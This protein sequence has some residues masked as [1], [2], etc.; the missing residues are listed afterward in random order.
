MFVVLSVLIP[1][2]AILICD[3]QFDTCTQPLG[4]IRQ[5]LFSCLT[6]NP[7]SV[8]ASDA[9]EPA[10]VCYSCSISCHGEHE[11]VELFS[12]RNFTCDCGTTRIKSGAACTLRFNPATDRKGDVSGEV[13]ATGNSYNQ[14]FQ[15]RFC[16]CGQLYNPHSEKGT[17]FQ[18]L[19]L[20][21]VEEGGCGEDWWHAECILGLPRDWYEK[22][23]KRATEDVVDFSAPKNNEDVNTVAGSNSAGT[24][25]EADLETTS[26]GVLEQ[27]IANEEEERP[28]PPGFP[29]EDD[30]EHLI[31]YKCT[32]TF[33]WITRYAGSPGFLEAVPHKTN[34]SEASQASPKVENQTTEAPQT[35]IQQNETQRTDLSRKRKTSDAAEDDAGLPLSKRSQ[36]SSVQA[37]AK[38]SIACSFD[39]IATKTFSSPVSLFLSADFRDQLCRCS[40]C[41]PLLAIHPQLLEEED[42]YEPPLS[43]G[44]DSEDG[45]GA[46]GTRSAGSRSLLDRGEAALSNM[47]RVRAIEGVM[48]YNHIRDKVKDFLKPFAESGTAVGAEDIKKYFEKLRGDDEAIREAAQGGAGRG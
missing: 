2:K 45:E 46:P 38:V 31:C 21:T 13:P 5:S 22:N 4:S 15:N 39:R 8:Q 14:N 16:G 3:Q 34:S 43:A 18:C 37:D 17:M 12:R 44:S 29:A 26:N 36:L 25:H 32:S 40:S 7:P 20:G 41:F 24:Q 1:R 27:S 47:D 33:P 10:G 11:L 30:F 6:C 28:L 42:T 23:R 35:A 48:A 19:G 9:Y